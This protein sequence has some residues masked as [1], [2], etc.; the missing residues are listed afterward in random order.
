MNWLAYNMGHD[1]ELPDASKSPKLPFLIIRKGDGRRAAR[2]ARA[3]L[4]QVHDHVARGVMA[5]LV[6]GSSPRHRTWS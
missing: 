4:V 3:R 5:L 2:S 6:A 1:I